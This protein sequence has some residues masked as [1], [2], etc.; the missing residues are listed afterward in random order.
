MGEV[1]PRSCEFGSQQP[2]GQDNDEIIL[3]Y[4]YLVLRLPNTDIMLSKLHDDTS[5]YKVN[6]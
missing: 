5:K 6:R 4:D 1:E 2:E 3:S